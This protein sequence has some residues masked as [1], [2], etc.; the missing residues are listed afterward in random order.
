MGYLLIRLLKHSFY[1]FCDIMQAWYTK[2]NHMQPVNLKYC[3]KGEV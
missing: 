2:I 1:G 3:Q